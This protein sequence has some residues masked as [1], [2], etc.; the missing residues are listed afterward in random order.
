[1][2][3]WSV[4]ALMVGSDALYTSEPRL[5]VAWRPIWRAAAGFVGDAP[6]WTCLTRHAGKSPSLKMCSG[7]LAVIAPVESVQP[8]HA[9]DVVQLGRLDQ[10]RMSDGNCEQRA[11]ERF[12]P[13]REEV[14]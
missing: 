13:E 3:I 1:M 8:E 5:V 2:L 14:L 9:V 12:F 6:A 10:F 4:A 11:F 7:A